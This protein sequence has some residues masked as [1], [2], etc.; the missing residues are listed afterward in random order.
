M[1]LALGLKV[2]MFV[3][4]EVEVKVGVGVELGAV[5]GDKED[6]HRYE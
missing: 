1:G 2:E 5:A 3:G 6:E 4:V